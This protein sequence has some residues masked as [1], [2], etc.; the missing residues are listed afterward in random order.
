[1]WRHYYRHYK[2]LLRSLRQYG[3]HTARPGTVFEI[4]VGD[5]TCVILLHPIVPL[6]FAIDLASSPNY[7]A[8]ASV[9]VVQ[10][11]NPQAFCLGC[12]YLSRTVWFAYG[13]ILL[14]SAAAKAL[15][16]ERW[17]TTDVDP[18][19]VALVVAL[20]A[21]PLTLLLARI[22]PLMT[23]FHYLFASTTDDAQATEMVYA[24]LFAVMPPKG[25]ARLPL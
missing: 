14:A 25:H 19:V 8:C 7:L 23:L 10:V 1:M 24:L 15:R 6:I 22:P 5:P 21:G 20:I 12:L 17:F 13:V 16:R 18:T 4:V 11:A 2:H 9:R 3:L